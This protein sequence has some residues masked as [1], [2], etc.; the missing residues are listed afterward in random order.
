LNRNKNVDIF[1]A[2]ALL[3]VVIYHGWV[4][5]GSVPLRPSFL[6]LVVMLGGE[7]GVTAFF[8]L[9]G[10]GIYHSLWRMEATIGKISYKDYWVKRIRRIGPQYYFCIVVI[11][12]FSQL[13]SRDNYLS[14]NGLRNIVTHLFFIHNLFPAYNGAINGVL[15]TMGIIVQFYVVAPLIY[16]GF[17]RYGIKMEIVCILFTV[18]MKA[19]M[20]AF[21]LPYTGHS[22][23]LAFFSG[24]QL[25]TALDNFTVGMCV[26]HVIKEGK[27]QLRGLVPLLVGIV[28]VAAVLAVCKAGLVYGIHTNNWSGYVWHSLL[29]LGLGGILLGISYMNNSGKSLIYRIFLWLSK[30]EYEIYIWHLWIWSN[31]IAQFSE[32]QALASTAYTRAVF[33]VIYLLTSIAI[34]IVVAKGMEKVQ[35]ILSR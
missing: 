13:L 19:G 21:V 16:K 4:L 2:V 33:Y 12:L 6:M 26:A 7:I 10:Y 31:L 1:R 11:V 24:R 5:M 29:A 8:A 15:W 9:S 18:L 28:S 3:L 35:N 20:Y 32:I 23:D 17:R 25:I 22:D 14:V 30:Y 27:I 34:G